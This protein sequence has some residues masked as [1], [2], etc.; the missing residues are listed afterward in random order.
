MGQ[1]MWVKK[2]DREVQTLANEE[3]SLSETVGEGGLEE[4][5]KNFNPSRQELM[6]MS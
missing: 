6:D 3:T 4:I 1:L 2:S 5:P